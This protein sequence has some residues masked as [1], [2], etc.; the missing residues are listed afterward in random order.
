MSLTKVAIIGAGLAGP[1]LAVFLKSM[2]YDPVVY[3][4]LD[5]PSDAGLGIG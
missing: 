5:G 2:G 4:R 3:E 1:V